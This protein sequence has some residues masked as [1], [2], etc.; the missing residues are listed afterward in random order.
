M[1]LNNF[2]AALLATAAF[3]AQITAGETGNTISRNEFNFGHQLGYMYSRMDDAFFRE[4]GT[5]SFETGLAT[6]YTSS[7]P[8]VRDHYWKKRTFVYIPLYF[9]LFPSDNIALQIDLT[10]LFV[11]VP[12]YDRNS[13]GGKS[14]RFRTKIRL[15]E[16]RGM[17]PAIAFTA[18][19][20]FSSAKPYVIWR[21]SLNY[22]QSNGLAGAGTGV[23]DYLLLFTL[24]KQVSAHTSLHGRI[25]LA[26]LG[27]PVDENG[28]GS[29]QAD[30]IPYGI[31]LRHDFPKRFSGRLEVSGMYNGL[32]ATQLAHY[33]VVRG[34]VLWAPVAGRTII[35]NVEHGLTEESDEW[36]GGLFGK[37]E[38]SVRRRDGAPPPRQP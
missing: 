5:W 37:F 29:R 31:S 28:H 16:E 26:P 33:S 8:R 7:M 38:W 21:D 22:D 4:R 17:R 15:C 27:S 2:I 30:E 13:M 10:D 18:G 3:T 24:S 11:E 32:R 12:Y 23:A 6:L 14:P 20:K 36:V 9:E 25:G 1:R 35:L 34:Q 19:V